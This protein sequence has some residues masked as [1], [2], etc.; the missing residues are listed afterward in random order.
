LLD[1]AIV[2]AEKLSQAQFLAGYGATQSVP[3]PMFSF[4]S[5]LGFMQAENGGIYG[6]LVATVFIFLP[7]FLLVLAIYPIWQTLSAYAPLQKGI[8]GANAAVVGLLAA[9][10]YDPIFIHGISQH[11]DLAIAALAFA[12]LSR[13]KIGVVWVVACCV[14]IK[15]LLVSIN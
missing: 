15:I 7:G 14:L 6:A 10:L 8:A 4:A 13:F 2:Y 3:G 11:A 5:Y 1:E 12:A 9:A